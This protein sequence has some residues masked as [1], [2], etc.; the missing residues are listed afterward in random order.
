MNERDF[1]HIFRRK[2][3]QIPNALPDD[4]IWQQLD[5]QLNNQVSSSTN[6][7]KASALLLLLAL[8]GS[9]FYLWKKLDKVARLGTTK[10]IVQIDTIQKQG[11]VYQTD[12]IVKYIYIKEKNVIYNENNE[13]QNFALN[14]GK[15]PI[16]TQKTNIFTSENVDNYKVLNSNIDN[17]LNKK[18]SLEVAKKEN[19]TNIFKEENTSTE[20]KEEA[21]ISEKKLENETVKNENST[22]QNTTKDSLLITEKNV[23]FSTKNTDNQTISN[24]EENENSAKIPTKIEPVKD[25]KLNRWSIGIN[26]Q[27]GILDQKGGHGSFNG[28]GLS[29]MKEISPK[30]RIRSNVDIQ[31]IEFEN[32][33]GR[34]F[35]K[36]EKPVIN[37]GETIVNWKIRSEPLAQLSIGIER[38]FNY[39]KLGFFVG[40]GT[41]V[42]L[43]LPHE[44]RYE[45]QNTS[46][47]P[48]FDNK[49]NKET[50]AAYAG[51]QGNAG[52]SFPIYRKI[53]A[54]LSTHYQ[55]NSNTEKFYWQNQLSGRLGLNYRF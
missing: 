48:T 6:W 46:G 14:S 20:I 54:T 15:N 2:I 30:W 13:E 33:D 16:L 31:E 21:I 1:D 49:E 27:S 37:P 4:M 43:V 53:S 19:N 36:H 8:L 17:L 24:K 34:N 18:E 41:G 51:F 9:N 5:S 26:T 40:I 12:T 55:Y 52:L 10:T 44:V 45:L 47:K 38:L 42:A 32:R 25:K 23:D 39:K 7:W 35:S 11:I 3:E 50:Y 29:V 22:L 28:I